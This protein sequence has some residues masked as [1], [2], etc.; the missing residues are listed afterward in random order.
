[1][2]F[3]GLGGLQKRNVRRHRRARSL[4]LDARRLRL[5]RGSAWNSAAQMARC[6]VAQ[7]VCCNAAQTVRC[8]VAYS[9]RCNAEPVRCSAEPTV[10]CNVVRCS[11]NTEQR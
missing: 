3:S 5:L 9:A 7:T 10:R 1:M 2:T 8:S 6:N 11:R 4:R